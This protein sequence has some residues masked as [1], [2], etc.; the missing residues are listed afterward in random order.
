M[1]DLNSLN[2]QNYKIL[3]YQRI[4]NNKTILKVESILN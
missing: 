2:A 3:G 4:N 1:L